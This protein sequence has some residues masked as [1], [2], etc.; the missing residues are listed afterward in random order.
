VGG[1]AGSERPTIAHSF[2]YSSVQINL[3]PAIAEAIVEF[4]ARV[5]DC[6]LVAAGRT[7]EPRVTIQQRLILRHP[8]QPISLFAYHPL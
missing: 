3:P 4:A 2:E 5:P 8:R 7:T 1:R 6:D